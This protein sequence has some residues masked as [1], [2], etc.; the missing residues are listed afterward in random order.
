MRIRNDFSF[1]L[2][3]LTVSVAACSGYQGGL[4][5]QSS[6]PSRGQTIVSQDQRKWCEDATKKVLGPAAEVLLCGHISRP[7]ALEV[8]GSVRLNGVKKS[9]LGIPVAKFAILSEQ[10]GQWEVELIAD[11][12]PVRN[13]VGY[14]GADNIDDSYGYSRYRIKYSGGGDKKDSFSLHIRFIS[15]DGIT[16]D[17]PLEVDWNPSVGRFQEYSESNVPS[18]FAQENKAPKHIHSKK[19]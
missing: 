9:E 16:E 3:L 4:S 19:R 8:L 15:P 14:L 6:T 13:S 2:F 12:R 11:Q 17:W 1:M 18:G 5:P 10:K 7:E